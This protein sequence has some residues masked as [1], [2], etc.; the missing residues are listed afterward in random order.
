MCLQRASVALGSS[1]MSHGRVACAVRH[2]LLL[3][4][5]ALAPGDK[6]ERTAVVRREGYSSNNGSS[7]Y[8]TETG[9]EG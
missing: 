6:A 3:L 4:S 9:A 7:C 5:L 1:V 8:L 2:A